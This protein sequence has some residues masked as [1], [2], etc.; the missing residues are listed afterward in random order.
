MNVWLL[1]TVSTFFFFISCCFHFQ[2]NQLQNHTITEMGD[3]V[4]R[5]QIYSPYAPECVKKKCS[6]YVYIYK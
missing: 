2:D 3:D 5:L 4:G 6:F 1:K